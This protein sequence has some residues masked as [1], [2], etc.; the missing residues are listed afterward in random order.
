VPSP[1]PQGVSFPISP[2]HRAAM[3]FVPC[4]S[5]VKRGPNVPFLS[6]TAPEHPTPS[7]PPFTL[8]TAGDIGSGLIPHHARPS[9]NRL[10]ASSS[11]ASSAAALPESV[12]R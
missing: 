11:A 3:S 7:W 6:A 10:L 5:G 9:F 8:L 1:A 12:S 4:P 2:W